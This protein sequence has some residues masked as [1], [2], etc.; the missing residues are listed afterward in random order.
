MPIPFLAAS[1][2][3]RHAAVAARDNALGQTDSEC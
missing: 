1:G 3:G 2:S